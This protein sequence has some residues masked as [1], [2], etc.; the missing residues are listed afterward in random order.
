M[1]GAGKRVV[2]VF[3]E[4]V[5]GGATVSVLR[6]IPHLVE[7]GWEPSFWVPRPSLLYDHLRA[8]GHDVA[9]AQREVGFSLQWLRHPP[10]P[11]AKL[12]TMPGWFTGLA[13]FVRERRPALVHANT[14]Y[15]L[16]DAA[17]A[18]AL[19]R[20]VLLHVHEMAPAGWKGAAARRAAG[21]LGLHVAAVSEAGAR[22][23][24]GGGPLPSIVHESTTLP[25]PGLERRRNG[26]PVV[27][28]VGWVCRRKGSDLFVEAARLVRERR[29]D[30]EFRL[31][32][33]HRDTPERPWAERVLAR[34]RAA[35]VVHV[36]RADTF[37]ELAGWDV[38][39]L[40]SRADPF[41]LVVLEAM[42]SGVPPVCT[43]VDGMAEQI[44]PGTGVLTAPEDPAALADGILTA[45]AD[46][47]T[48]GAAARERVT[49]RFL[50]EH[51]ARRL[52]RLYR[53]IAR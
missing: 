37:H 52:D 17:V 45:L 8:A 18:R 30:V 6:A 2:V 10:G 27:G 50:A 34:A 23:W 15:T 13:R 48:M 36:P 46:D 43:R 41:P 49:G 7:R 25:P 29:P 4:E 39:V 5:L 3:H 38:F 11:A 40:P 9:G 21:A 12:R 1:G 20:P 31:V 14:L 33:E 32:G 28:T 16:A 42:A 35:G 51:Q 24:A 26:H 47:G 53:E 19:R 22:R 44:A